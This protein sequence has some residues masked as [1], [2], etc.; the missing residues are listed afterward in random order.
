MAP[1]FKLLDAWELPAEGGPD[2]FAALIEIMTS[3]D[4]AH[5]DSRA[6]RALF[7]LRYRL[8]RWFGWDDAI[9]KL[10]VPGRTETTRREWPA[11]GRDRQ[12]VPARRGGRRARVHREPPSIRPRGDD[13]VGSSRPRLAQRA[14]GQHSD[15][16]GS[17]PRPLKGTANGPN[18]TP[19][20]PFATPGSLAGGAFGHGHGPGGGRRSPSRLPQA[21]GS[22]DRGPAPP[23]RLGPGRG[24]P[25]LA[26]RREAMG[27]RDIH[28]GVEALLGEPVRWG[29]VKA[30]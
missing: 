16:S 19:F 26:D 25:C 29:S 12:D 3:L 7:S 17:Q 14:S 2:E 15:P 1:D 24:H 4:P 5:G 21:G 8:G 11:T 9:S 28:R 18:R 13:A 20:Q 27:A 6:T 10:P 23:T 30:N 22:S